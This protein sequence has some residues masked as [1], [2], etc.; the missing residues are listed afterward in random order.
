LIKGRPADDLSHSFH[1]HPRRRDRTG[2]NIA[3]GALSDNSTAFK[4]E[5]GRLTQK[6]QKHCDP[7]TRWHDPGYDRVESFEGAFSDLNFVTDLKRFLDDPR[8]RRTND[9]GQL[10]DHGIRNGRPK[11]SEMDHTSYPERVLNIGQKLV[12][13]ETHEKVVR[14][15][16]FGDPDRAAPGRASKPDTGSK[17]LELALTTQAG[18]SD[19]FVF[20]L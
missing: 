6:I 12:S 8:F 11:G 19:M 3:P 4:L 13:I 20:G 10:L 14:E 16:G 2:T 1:R 9:T 17:H 5:N 18:G 7:L 15:K